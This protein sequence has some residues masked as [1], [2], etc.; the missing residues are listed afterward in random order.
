M[1]SISLVKLKITPDQLVSCTDQIKG[2]N[3]HS[4]SILK[5]EPVVVL[6]S[7]KLPVGG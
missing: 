1:S 2:G 6:G 5:A 4:E 7:V 3:G